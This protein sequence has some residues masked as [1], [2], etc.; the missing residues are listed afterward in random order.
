MGVKQKNYSTR[1]S[2]SKGITDRSLPLILIFIFIF[3]Y[4]FLTYTRIEAEVKIVSI[5]KKNKA[6]ESTGD[7]KFKR[8]KQLEPEKKVK[9]GTVLNKGDQLESLSKH[10]ILVIRCSDNPLSEFKFSEKFHILVL[11]GDGKACVFDL[12]GG[13]ADVLTGQPTSI[14]AG[15]ETTMASEHTQYGVR[16]VPGEENGIRELFV[17]EGKVKIQSPGFTGSLDQGKKLIV[18]GKKPASPIKIR[19]EDFKRAAELYAR[20]SANMAQIIILERTSIQLT[21]PGRDRDRI[22]A[23]VPTVRKVKNTAKELIPQFKALYLDVFTNPTNPEYRLKLATQQV[24]CHISH[25]A[26][27]H[28]NL[29]EEYARVN[30]RKATSALVKSIAFYQLNQSRNGYEEFMKAKEIEPSAFKDKNLKHYKFLKN[31]RK[32]IKKEYEKQK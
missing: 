12:L 13:S 22:S 27:Y 21:G 3:I 6:T 4:L 30:L 19:Q 8:Y 25:E 11:P 15:G 31:L 29:A 32:E 14:S 9:V 10:I 20:V 1:G 16:I 2:L 24:N 28:S 26:I 7:I 18:S 17:Y 23:S 5:L